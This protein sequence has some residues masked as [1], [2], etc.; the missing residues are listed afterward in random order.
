MTY[1]IVVPNITMRG[2]V[3]E[4]F[5]VQGGATDDDWRAA[6]G[7]RWQA[8]WRDIVR[9]DHDLLIAAIP[10]RRPRP[11]DYDQPLKY[12]VAFTT[13]DGWPFKEGRYTLK[14]YGSFSYHRQLGKKNLIFIH[15]TICA[16]VWPQLH[17][18]E[19]RTALFYNEPF[20]A[21]IY[22][23]ADNP[24]GKRVIN[25]KDITKRA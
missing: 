8:I 10:K 22:I 20:T 24:K 3:P 18:Q 17:P 11:E 1:E 19:P 4:L 2:Q 13:G 25:Y 16:V 12:D 21:I 5:I 7:I 23:T 9:I 15:I 14:D 6:V